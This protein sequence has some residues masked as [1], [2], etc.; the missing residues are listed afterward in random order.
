[1]TDVAGMPVS[2]VAEPSQAPVLRWGILGP[3]R[4]AETFAVSVRTHTRQRIVAVGS[5]DGARGTAFAQR[6][7][8][9]TVH[10]SYLALVGDPD[11]DVVYVATPNPFHARCAL[12][13]VQAGKHVVVEKPF[14]MSADEALRVADA[15]TARGVFVMEAMWP[16]FLPAMDV[17]GQVL[18]GGLLG[19]VQALS[20]D[21]GEY[22]TPDPASRLFD[23]MLGGG[24]LLD[25]GI[26]LVSF[27][28]FALGAPEQILA[29]GS[30]T[31]TGVD[32]RASIV[33]QG[34]ADRQAH[35]FTTLEAR[36]PTSAFLT[37]SR[38]V[39]EV[40]APFYLPPAIALTAHA[41]EPANA[42]AAVFA[43]Q[44]P[45]DG[46][47]YEVAEAARMIS[48]GRTQ[49][50]LLPLEETVQIMRTMDAVRDLLRA[51]RAD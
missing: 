24:A 48:A 50:P 33:L 13:A 43:Q 17:I 11:V 2:R 39:L 4:I 3:G 42:L 16:R 18:A 45:E 31:G 28:S 21:L 19:D 29:A 37:G 51:E 15:A 36:T 22:F 12:L 5:R 34:P 49:S 10:D 23:P 46:L 26:Y 7:D 41:A 47:C 32:A 38:G 20:A 14:A 8:V 27:A 30:F 35:L 40:H 25:L 1:M 44:R 6:H 9:P